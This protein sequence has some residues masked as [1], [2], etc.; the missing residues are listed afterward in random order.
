M[1]TTE[2]LSLDA[3]GLRLRGDDEVV[4]DT[5]F[6]GRRIWSFHLLRDSVASRGV[7]RVEWPTSMRRFLE[8]TA[9]VAVVEHL[10]GAELYRR[11]TTFNGSHAPIAFVDDEGRPLGVDKSGRMEHTF[12]TRSEDQVA[13]LLDSIQQ[14]LGALAEAGVEAF[15][16]YGTLLGAVREQHLIGHDSDAD[17]GYVSRHDHPYDVV[18]ESFAL[19]RRLAEQGYAITRYSGGAFKVDVVEADGAVRGLDVF[20]GFLT[21]GRLYLM[22]E[23]GHPFREEWIFP[24]GSCTLEGRTLPA[25]AQPE[26]MLEAMYG[27]G[28][29]V[30]DPA[31]HFETPYPTVRRLNGWFR[32]TR[33]FRDEWERRFSRV[34]EK[35]PKGAPSDLARYVVES[36]GV[37][38]QVVDVGCGRGGDA[39]WFAEQ[40]AS[41][42]AYDFVPRASTAVQR[43]AQ[44]AGL[45]LEVRR[46]NLL[47]WR[48]VLGEGARLAHQPGPRTLLARHVADETTR[49]GRE[50]LWRFASMA[51]REGGSL[52]V[53]GGAQAGEEL[54]TA[55]AVIVSSDLAGTGRV[56]ARWQS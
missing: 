12:D 31:Y 36:E 20:G 48:S 43:R 53:E 49:F 41:V 21:G 15:P 14:V 32:G 25:P 35:P 19:Q 3:D 39:L 30:P 8:G 52:Y 11:P 24:L 51:L 10:S 4:L 7:R 28:W 55:G 33:T 13:P 17:L 27:P 56:V 2:V 18:R 23:V 34:R 9:E 47:E 16:A 38:A 29:K 1:S 6:D 44:Q 40:G 42:T 50:S 37:P 5:L 46:L 26:R 45:P 54:V 22:G